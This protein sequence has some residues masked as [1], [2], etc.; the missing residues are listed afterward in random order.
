MT[1]S[2]A[3]DIRS[4]ALAMLAVTLFVGA[5]AKGDDA[6]DKTGGTPGAAA[7]DAS[8]PGTPETGKGDHGT[9]HLEVTGGPHAGSYHVRLN[10][11]TCSYGL[12]GEKM[13]G[14]QYSIDSKDPKEF[15]SL[16]LMVPDAPAAAKGTSA[17]LI[18]AS[19]GPLFDNAGRSYEINT[20]ADTRKKE[21]KGT[22]SIDDRGSTG[23]VTFD[24]TTAAGVGLKGTIECKTLIRNG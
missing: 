18:T 1:F 11:P 22:I 7:S 4:G 24:G 16:Q 21:G 23:K 19:F 10:Q 15:S 9:I 14:N 5:C 6:D 20:L 13:W 2:R 17:F 8:A 3:L 12:A